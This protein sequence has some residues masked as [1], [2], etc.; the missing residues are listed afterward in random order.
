MTLVVD[1][2]LNPSPEQVAKINNIANTVYTALL[3]GD[4]RYWPYVEVEGQ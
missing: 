3:R 1:K 4:I 2:N